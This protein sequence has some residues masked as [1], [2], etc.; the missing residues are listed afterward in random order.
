[1]RRLLTIVM[2][3]LLLIM[4]QAGRAAEDFVV[5]DAEGPAAQ[6]GTDA[7]PTTA[8]AES[9]AGWTWKR[10][11]YG[12]IELG[13]AG[14]MPVMG[15]FVGGTIGA[16]VPLKGMHPYCK[17][18]V[19]YTAVGGGAVGATA[20]A[21]L[22]PVIVAEGVFDT[23]TGGAFAERPF[24]WFNVKV[25]LDGEFDMSA[26]ENAALQQAAQDTQNKAQ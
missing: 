12:P 10:L 24:A 6:T 25:P 8:A 2:S 22:A 11:A 3:G 4:A 23:L 16:I 9:G 13:A 14:L 7:G 15:I 20:G 1:M 21:M 5:V 26:I 18:L 19:P 17:V